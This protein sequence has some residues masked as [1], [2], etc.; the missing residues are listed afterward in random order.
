MEICGPGL[1]RGHWHGNIPGCDASLFPQSASFL[2]HATH[3][4]VA[5]RYFKSQPLL[6][7]QARQTK[8]SGRRFAVRTANSNDRTIGILVEE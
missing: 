1:Y 5:M 8:L 6:W 7:P 3:F 4:Q 2:P